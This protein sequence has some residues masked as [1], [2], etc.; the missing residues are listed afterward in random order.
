LEWTLSRF[1]GSEMVD[2]V[3][4]GVMRLLTW[5]AKRLIDDDEEWL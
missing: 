1:D 4:F 2:G 5:S 3:L